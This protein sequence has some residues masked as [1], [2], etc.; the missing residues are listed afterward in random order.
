MKY[1]QKLQMQILWFNDFADQVQSDHRAY[2]NACEYADEMEEKRREWKYPFVEGQRYYTI[3]GNEVVESVWDDQS[4]EMHDENPNRQYFFTV[5]EAV[6]HYRFIRNKEM[7]DRVMAWVE[8]N[9]HIRGFG[10]L[11][12]AY[13]YMNDV[14]R[15]SLIKEEKEE[16]CERE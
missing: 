15:L 11:V 1:I 6:W 8:D 13:N 14:P 4:E 16:E 2:K 7:L 12:E 10:E 5:D 3:E 9:T